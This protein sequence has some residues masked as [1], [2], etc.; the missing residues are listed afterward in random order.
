MAPE[1]KQYED[2]LANVRR[3]GRFH[4]IRDLVRPDDPYVKEVAAVLLQAPDFIEASQ[5]FVAEFADYS[6]EIG[7]YWSYPI[8]TLAFKWGDCDCLAILLC[9]ILRN[10]IS[11]DRVFCSIGTWEKRG[12]ATGHMWVTVVDL[13]GRDRIIEATAPSYRRTEGIY[14]LSAFFNDEYTWST[15]RGLKEFGL[16]PF[17]EILDSLEVTGAIKVPARA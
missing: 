13:R 10:G 8:E 15:P 12:K 4:S 16:M 1:M 17:E 9:S 7:D 5:D 2:L 6:E 3:D 11:A 14:R